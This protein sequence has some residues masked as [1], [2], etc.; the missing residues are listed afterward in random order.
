MHPPG[1]SE[2]RLGLGLMVPGGIAAIVVDALPPT[3]LFDPRVVAD[4]VSGALFLGGWGL[5]T[6]G[7]D[8]L[9]Q[10]GFVIGLAGLSLLY[11]VGVVAVAV[12]AVSI[13]RKT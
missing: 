7:V 4:I 2:L 13:V 12:S 9:A 3:V 8:A 6:E 10:T 11:Y 5:L 1:R